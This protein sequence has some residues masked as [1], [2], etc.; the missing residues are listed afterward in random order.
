MNRC[1][2]QCCHGFTLSA[3]PG[4]LAARR[5]AGDEEAA[6]LLGMIVYL[7][8]TQQGDDEPFIRY[9]CRNLQENGDCGIYDSRPS[10]CRRYPYCG[11]C[12]FAGCTWD[13]VKPVE[14]RG[15]AA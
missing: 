4:V 3:T 10:M 1:S 14:M 2:G 5:A 11:V 8:T 15:A 12:R 13:A 7:D 6:E 9:S